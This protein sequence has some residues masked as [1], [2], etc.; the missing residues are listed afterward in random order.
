[1]IL[2]IPGVYFHRRRSP[3]PRYAQDEL[4]VG[5]LIEVLSLWILLTAGG[6]LGAAACAAVYVVSILE[7]PLGPSALW[8]VAAMGALSPVCFWRALVIWRRLTRG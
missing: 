2:L 8:G 6:F 5:P 7:F 1:V 3:Q 4:P